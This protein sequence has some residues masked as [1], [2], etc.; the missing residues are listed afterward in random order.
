MH[1]SDPRFADL[2]ISALAD[3]TPI[4][5]HTPRK[6]QHLGVHSRPIAGPH[7]ALSVVNVQKEAMLVESLVE[8]QLREDK[9]RQMHPPIRLAVTPNMPVAEVV[10][11]PPND[12]LFLLSHAGHDYL[13]YNVFWAYMYTCA[14]M[15]IL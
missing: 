2:L 3:T 8:P 7:D 9:P 4:M 15:Q 12:I 13:L 10:E 11:V 1:F 6:S 14:S 5:A